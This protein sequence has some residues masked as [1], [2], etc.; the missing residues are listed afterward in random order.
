M[1]F[2]I[3]FSFLSFVALFAI[4]YSAPQS[5]SKS[6]VRESFLLATLIFFL[7]VA[8]STEILGSF[9]L[10]SAFS[11]RLLWII[12]FVVLLGIC[13]Y[14]LK[15]AS[16]LLSN[17][18]YERIAII[19]LAC[20][21]VG[22]LIICIIHPSTNWDSMTYHLS[23]VMHWQQNQSLEYYAS[24]IERQIVFQGFAEYFIL[25]TVLLTQNDYFVNIPQWL[26][27]VG[28]MAT[29]SLIASELGISRKG[30]LLTAFL[31]LAIPIALLQVPSTQNDL[32]GSFFVIYSFGLFLKILKKKYQYSLLLGISIG[33]AILT[34]GTSYLYL[35][36][37]ILFFVIF[38][39]KE[40]TYVLFRAG[41]ITATAILLINAG[42]F[43]RN[44][45]TF[46]SLLISNSTEVNAVKNQTYQLQ[47]FYSNL[48]RNFSNNLVLPHLQTT[49][50]WENI[51]RGLHKV[52]QIDIDDKRT[53]FTNFEM[54]YGQKFY[55]QD[56]A[57]SPLHA[58]AFL[59]LLPI[60]YVFREKLSKEFKY[61]F[62]WGLGGFL[63]LIFMLK[64]QPFG[65]RFQIPFWT[66]VSVWIAYTI[67][68]FWQKENRL[69]KW[70]FLV[71]YLLLSLKAVFYLYNSANLALKEEKNVWNT[72]RE[73]LYFL[74]RPDLY[75][76]YQR[77]VEQIIQTRCKKVGL[78]LKLDDWE[79]PL[80]K[81][82]HNRGFYPEIRH[83]QVEN[84]TK[85]L[86][87][88]NFQP[89]IVVEIDN[90]KGIA[91]IR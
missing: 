29:A 73:E 45:Y 19:I 75:P 40:R 63:L 24:H 62:I 61:T 27:F 37:L 59:I 66:W 51:V 85:S 57:P 22:L 88:K 84:I 81:M 41:L 30:Q 16:F 14:K 72:P 47:S 71:L 17:D 35:T 23:R 9:H 70:F 15:K 49:V 5:L 11:V 4:L 31:V 64:W 52:A 21:L 86:E 89:C 69:K 87:D 50:F 56:Y 42:L 46:R 91:K 8:I 76:S 43:F 79:Y 53:S 44:L 48:I 26:S 55:S 3:V 65:V 25:H 78:I 32:V 6:K 7:F 38:W 20:L 2:F 67:D 82:L 74:A 1:N 77:L 10:L 80:W 13:F 33:M 83:I 12:L 18:N 54:P 34:K 36:P 39:L 90:H 28:L 60:W 58:W 68:V